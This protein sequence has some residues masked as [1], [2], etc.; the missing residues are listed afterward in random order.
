MSALTVLRRA[1][2]LGLIRELDYHF[3][4]LIAELSE[5]SPEGVALAAA[6][7]SRQTGAG[8]VCV[9][10]D[11]WAGRVVFDAL[12]ELSAPPL[13]AWRAML[14]ASPAVSDTATAPLVLDGDAVYLARYWTFETRLA[15]ALRERAASWAAGVER[16][17]LAAGV[18]RLLGEAAHAADQRSAAALAVLRRL[19]VISGGPGTGKTRTVAAILALLLDQH[20]PLRIALAAPTG[21]AAAR[22]AESIQAVKRELP[23][24]PAQ[25]AAL[26]ESA[27][28]LH[29]LLGSRPGR[30]QPRHH[31]GNPLHVD[32]L[33]IDEASMVD[34]P[35]L[36]RAVDALPA[37]ARLVLLGDRDQLASVEA[38]AVLA[39]ICGEPGAPR[40]SADMRAALRETAD[41]EHEAHGPAMP[42]MADSIALLRHS[43][44][45]TA[46]SGIGALAQAINAGDA[47]AVQAVL[48]AGW[49]GVRRVSPAAL[50]P[51]LDERLGAAL[52]ALFAAATP[53]E[54]LARL[55]RLRILCAVREGPFG[56]RELNALIERLVRRRL[57][58]DTR[59]PWYKGR[60]VMVQDNDYALGLF[61]GDVGI[62]WPDA[63]DELKV[64]FE[65]G[66]G[67]RA[68]HPGRMPAHETVYAMTVHKSQGSE[69]D[70]VLLILPRQDAPV[71]TRELLYT[72]ITRARQDVE[73]WADAHTIDTA[74]ARRVRRASGLY[75]RVW[76]ARA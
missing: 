33:V 55:G 52:D 61:N 69:F 46:G 6:L 62:A 53:G 66:D 43:Y 17:R 40:Y 32:L 50:A 64:F 3:A 56:V 38:G 8:D 19:A 41:A 22:L 44:R 71:L 25:Q 65:S 47:A 24:D 13:A 67:L 21:K 29:R 42:P 60:P 28:T 76:G 18:R 31:A 34:L 75:A 39:D 72:A 74:V 54:A 58:V 27:Q 9:R 30:S 37:H 49:P 35:L 10:L 26:P 36:A 5:E 73:I 4:A 7:V 14:Q 57:S 59:K 1:L 63:A 15:A 51:R 48:A 16:A 12:P 45:F 23:L 68:V 20:P 11:A 2:A 70:E